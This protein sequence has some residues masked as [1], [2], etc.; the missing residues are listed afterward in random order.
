MIF[1]YCAQFSLSKRYGDFDY[2]SLK[3]LVELRHKS[4]KPMLE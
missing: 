4:T 3:N 2:A 1:Y